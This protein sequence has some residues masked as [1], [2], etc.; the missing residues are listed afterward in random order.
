QRYALS[1]TNRRLDTERAYLFTVLD[2]VSTGII[3]FTDDLEILSVNRAALQMLQLDAPPP[4]A[5]AARRRAGCWPSKTRRSW[6]RRRSSRRGTKPRA[7]SRTRSR[8]R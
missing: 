4:R 2:S 6:C 3:A 1:D 5:S 7:A 8:I